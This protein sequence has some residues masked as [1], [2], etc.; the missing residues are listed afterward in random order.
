MVK[1]L[2]ALT[3]EGQLML[4]TVFIT[5]VSWLIIVLAILSSYCFGFPGLVPHLISIFEAETWAIGGV[6]TVFLGHSGAGRIWGKT[7]NMKD[8]VEQKEDTDPDKPAVK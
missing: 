4:I 1:W 6:L 8:I 7:D 3:D 5:V 2:K